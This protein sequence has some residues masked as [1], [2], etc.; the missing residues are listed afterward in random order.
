[1]NVPVF[2]RPGMFSPY[3]VAFSLAIGDTQPIGAKEPTARFLR[4]RRICAPDRAAC[5]SAVVGWGELLSVGVVKD[6]A[7][8]GETHDE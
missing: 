1:M 5:R 8:V 7:E 6:F 4:P 2:A 3:L